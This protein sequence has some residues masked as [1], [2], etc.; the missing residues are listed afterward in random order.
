M[1]TENSENGWFNREPDVEERKQAEHTL[2]Y[3]QQELR[4]AQNEGRTEDVRHFTTRVTQ[5]TTAVAYGFD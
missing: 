4:R 3:L 2:E 1:H 5:Q